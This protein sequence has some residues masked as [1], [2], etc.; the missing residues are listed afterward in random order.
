M[1]VGIYIRVSTEEQV[2][3]D[4]SISAQR[5]KLKAYCISQDWTDYKFYVDESKSAKDTNRPYLK[6]ML[7]HIQQGLIDVV[8]V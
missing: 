3:E 1:T 6:L 4:F 5:E 8:L 2:R 7:D